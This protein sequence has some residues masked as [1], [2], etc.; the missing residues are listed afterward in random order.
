MNPTGH[1]SSFVSQVGGSNTPEVPDGSVVIGNMPVLIVPAPVSPLV[2]VGV[3]TDVTLSPC[4][5]PCEVNEL[6]DPDPEDAT[7]AVV[8]AG[9]ELQ[10]S[11]SAAPRIAGAWHRPS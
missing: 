4:V 1:L 7:S 5:S 2:L 11:K 6:V 10:A 9:V 3:G 8:V